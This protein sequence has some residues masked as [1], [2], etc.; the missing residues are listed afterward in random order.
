MNNSLWVSG[1]TSLATESYFTNFL[2][3][4]GHFNVQKYQDKV[5]QSTQLKKFMNL[6]ESS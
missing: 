2:S 1:V 3:V 6:H 5:G 4:A